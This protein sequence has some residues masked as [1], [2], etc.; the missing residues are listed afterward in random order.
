MLESFLMKREK[1]NNFMYLCGAFSAFA[2]LERAEM[3]LGYSPFTIGF[4]VALC[5]ARRSFILTVPAYLV[6]KLIFNPSLATL[7]SVIVPIIVLIGVYALCFK[8]KKSLTPFSV[9]LIA[10]VCRI[11]E[12]VQAV[13]DGVGT[14]NVM[15]GV[16][17]GQ[18]FTYVATVSAYALF[19]RGVRTKFTLDE[20]IS[21]SSTLTVFS[22]GFY[23]FTLF[24]IRPFLAVSVFLVLVSTYA[25]GSTGLV[26]SAVIGLGAGFG[27]DYFLTV[28][29]VCG[30]LIVLAFRTVS[31]YLSG[32][33]FVLASC[34]IGYYFGENAFDTGSVIMIALGALVFCMLP[35]KIMEEL[36]SLLSAVQERY[37]G[38]GIVNRN[39]VEISRKM[40]SLASLFWDLSSLVLGAA[41]NSGSEE[42]KI[43]TL[44]NK[45]IDSLCGNCSK[46]EECDRIL[47]GKTAEVIK[48]LAES[49]VKRGKATLLELPS[50]L[51]GSCINVN[52]VIPLVNEKKEELAQEIK[53]KSYTESGRLLLGE[54]LFGTGELL[55]S[56]AT[57]MRRTIGFDTARERIVIDELAYKNVVCNEVIIESGGERVLL[58]A[59]FGEER[60]RAIEKVVSKVMKRKM[61]AFVDKEGEKKG[62]DMVI[63]EP[64]S[65]LDM[66][67]GEANSTKDGEKTSGD[68]RLIVRP[69]RDRY[70][71]AIADGMGSGEI[72]ERASTRAVSMVEGFYKAGFSHNVIIN[73]VNKMLT[74]TGE[75]CYN[76]LDMCVC[77]VK[78]KSCDFIKMGACPAFFKRNDR[79]E[80]LECSALPMGVFQE[81]SPT[82]IHK[83][84]KPNDMIVLVSDGVTDSIGVDEL[85]VFLEGLKTP[86]PQ[87]MANL[88]KK[89]ATAL[90]AVDDVS[91]AVG[92]VYKLN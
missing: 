25:L 26:V 21:L 69:A 10:L 77:D 7:V 57:E 8:L 40:S 31:P 12:T 1:F 67:F 22:A 30:A 62:F 70:I 24:G 88:I 15:T 5:F 32:L 49:A 38:R 53:E 42:E 34:A 75:D 56:F 35:K 79:V 61:I 54:Q 45:V 84:L 29:L 23:T 68:S 83:D 39:R 74:F 16:V 52:S 48:P 87:E 60:K 78:S 33:G 80:V 82:V 17:L 51:T 59:K 81:I 41:K 55:G 58:F 71:L 13:F 28:P 44:T 9:N 37:G 64:Q 92:K 46:R 63:L 91:V 76:T 2:V 11:P 18:V 73:L 66:A 19:V 3:G 65:E 72:A 27:G 4:L 47:G 86:N 90:G 20:L 36:A 43:E 6:A 14:Y 85:C 50:Y 89:R